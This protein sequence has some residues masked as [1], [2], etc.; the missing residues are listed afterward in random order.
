M[1]L[2]N[3]LLK[4]LK[5]VVICTPEDYAPPPSLQ[6]F[7]P[8]VGSRWDGAPSQYDKLER[9]GYIERLTPY[10]PAHH[11]DYAVVTEAGRKAAEP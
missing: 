7:P 9:L 6:I 11:Y 4:A 5:H 3:R 2:D 10:N 8:Y 1:N